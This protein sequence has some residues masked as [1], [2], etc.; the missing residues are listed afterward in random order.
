MGETAPLQTTPGSLGIVGGVGL[1]GGGTVTPR[2][3]NAIVE[4]LRARIAACREHHRNCQGRYE[5]SRAESSDRE[6]ENTLQLLT[7]VQHGQGTR[8]TNKHVKNAPPPDYHHHHQQQHQHLLGNSRNGNEIKVEQSQ[9]TS[10]GLDQRN[11]ALI[12]LQGSLKRRLVVNVSA[13]HNN[14]SNGI[15]DSAYLDFKKIRTNEHL[16]GSQDVYRATEGLNQSSGGTMPMDQSAHRKSHITSNETSDVFN[17]TLKD[18]KKEP[19]ESLPCSKHFDP[20]MSQDNLYR[21]GEELEEQ[22]MDPDL[23]ELFNEL[24]YISVPPMTDIE[25]QNMI[26]ITIKQDE[27]FNIDLGQNHRNTPTSLPMDKIV[28]KSEYPQGLDHARV[29]SPQLRPSSTGPTFSMTSTSLTLSQSTTAPQNQVQVSSSTNRLANWQEL[30]HAQQLKQM[31]A[32]RQHTLIQQHQ[33]N[34][35]PSWSSVPPPRPFGQEKVPSPFRQQ[36]LSPHRTPINAAPVNGSQTKVISNYLYKPSPNSHSSQL[37][38]MNQQTSQDASKNLVTSGHSTVEPNHGNTKPLFHFN[39]DQTNHQASLG[40]NSQGKPILQFTKQQSSAATQQHEQ[41]QQAKP[42]P[43][44]NLPRTQTFP[45]KMLIPKIQQNQQIS[46]LHYPGVH[47]QQDQ[48]STTPQGPG[49]SSTTNPS[50]SPGPG[51]GFSSQQTLLSQQL[52][53]K[54]NILQRQMAE[55]KQQLIMQQQILSGTEKSKSQDQLNRHLTRPPPDYKDQRRTNM[56]VQQGNQYSGVNSN[57]SIATA[58]PPHNAQNSGHSSTSHGS[59]MSSSLQGSQNMYGNVPCSQQT[60]Y[61]VNPGVAHMQQQTSPNSIGT[62]QNGHVLQRQSTGNGLPPF[63]TVAAVN[64]PQ[65]RSGPGQRTSMVGQRAPNAMVSTSSPQNWVS[66]E[67]K[68]QEAPCF[69]DNNQFQNQSL[70]SVLGSQHFPQRSLPPPNQVTPGTQLRPLTQ[71]NQGNSGQAIE[72]LRG[73]NHGQPRAPILTNLSP[74]EGTTMMGN[75]FTTANQQSR[76]FQGTDT[77]NDLGSF[78]FLSQN[79]GLGPSLNNDSDF[80]DAL[81][82]TGHINDDWMKDINLDEIFKNHS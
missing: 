73:L 41:L 43:N 74:Q 24:T 25:L 54:P 46:G 11:S 1:L 34:Q 9:Q 35:S 18:I 82:K 64:P 32:N 78:E 15:S 27:P 44:Q 50:S 79:N 36:Q 3:H 5:R 39:Q 23:Q 40:L 6:R 61:N 22:L 71:M 67:A 10:N 53:E 77:S 4:R 72:S 12:A 49:S 66:P 28:I 75:N 55:Q 47:Q 42:L 38:M 13:N 81:L 52:M 65:F 58:L 51:S 17:L 33:P 20:Q 48:H 69:T 14:R 26:N 70:Q 68:K 80:I 37:D 60:M 62:N 57:S 63:S 21:Y 30:S 8:K 19:G 2:V 7:L 31:A 76:S 45:H 29:D 16:P 56:S 59:R